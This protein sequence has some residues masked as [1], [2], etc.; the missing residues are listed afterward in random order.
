MQLMNKMTKLLITAAALLAA[1]FFC[2]A[3]ETAG[4]DATYLFAARDTCDL[5][6][7]IYEP[8]PGAPAISENPTVIFAFG[9]GFVSGTRN[10]PSDIKWF[11]ML[12]ER[13][14][15]VVSI[16]YRLGLNGAHI[17]GINLEAA[18]IFGHA[19]DIAVED[20]FSA[21]AFL[22]ENAG[23][24]GINP[25]C[26]IAAGSSAG[27]ITAL[28]AEWHICNRSELTST[29][30]EGF[31]Y[32]GVMSFAGAIY[33]TK[34]IP[35]FN[36]APCPILMFHGDSDKIVNF[37]KK[38]IF[39]LYFGG[40]FDLTKIFARKGY[41]YNIYRFT[42]KSHEIAASKR[43]NIA[44]EMK[45]IEENVLKGLHRVVDATVDDPGVITPEWAKRG[46][47]SLY[48]KTPDTN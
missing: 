42:G 8:A 21:T 24:L 29:L 12:N 7:D 26:I 31:N 18:R 33:S 40:S 48:E 13:G 47:M 23:T 14:I 4:P 38:Q 28:E 11:R 9:G 46:L 5:Y 43:H 30:P 10:K 32:A 36:E 1:G 6:L 17:T 44:E 3:E 27:A 19:I 20:L 2:R 37:G 34:G 16:D 25:G 35:A 45:F 15:R 22:V 39:G 41:N